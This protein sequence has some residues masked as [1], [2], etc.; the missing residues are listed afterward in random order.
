[1]AEQPGTGLSRLTGFGNQRL[2][3]PFGPAEIQ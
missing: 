3:L 1:M 2:P